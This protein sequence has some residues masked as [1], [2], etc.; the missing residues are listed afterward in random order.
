MV[1]F[2]ELAAET[3]WTPY[4]KSTVHYLVELIRGEFPGFV[5]HNPA[6][7]DDFGPASAV[8]RYLEEIGV[9]K[10]LKDF[11]G[12]LRPA[13]LNPAIA[14]CI[15][16]S[17]ERPTL[18]APIGKERSVRSVAEKV[19]DGLKEINKNI[20]E[21]FDSVHWEIF[22]SGGKSQGPKVPTRPFAIPKKKIQFTTYQ[23]DKRIQADFACQL[24]PNRK[25]GWSD[26]ASRDFHRARGGF[27]GSFIRINTG[28]M[29]E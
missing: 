3:A 4:A 6:W 25:N 19:Y 23:E 7:G 12:L 1:I 8:Y 26:L 18:L 10:F 16:Y 22:V 17:L 2:N 24:E 21:L 15:Y 27:M 9:P 29:A 20:P 28:A 14:P 5:P 11:P 13:H